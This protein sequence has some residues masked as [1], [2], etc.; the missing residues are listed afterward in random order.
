MRPAFVQ[1]RLPRNPLLRLLLA[2]AGIAVLSFFALAGAAIAAVVLLGFG[3]RSL[4]WK[5]RGGANAPR[6]R[7]SDVIEGDFEAMLAQLTPAPR[8]FALAYAMF[9]DAWNQRMA[10]ARVIAQSHKREL[11]KV[12]GQ[13][14]VLLDRIVEATSNTVVAAYEKRIAQLEREKLLLAERSETDDRPSGTFEELFKLACGFLSNPH[15][16]WAFGNFE[17]RKLVLRLTFADRLAYLPNGGFQTPKTTLPFKL[18]GEPNMGKC[19]MAEREGFEPPMGLHPCRI[20]S[21][22]HSTT[23]PPLRGRDRPLPARRCR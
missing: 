15:K 11:A 14:A 13:I 19:E 20:S 8:L 3:L 12:E 5:L 21:A 1:L 7:A 10:Q 4:G 22:V 16:L 9:K 2:V 23:L 17:Y 6:E 18:L